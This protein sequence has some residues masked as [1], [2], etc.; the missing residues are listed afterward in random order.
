MGKQK[1]IRDVAQLAGVS[2]ATASRVLSDADY[3]IRPQLRQRVREAAEK[4]EYVR[5]RFAVLRR[6]A[7]RSTA[8]ITPTSLH[9]YAYSSTNDRQPQSLVYTFYPTRPRL[10]TYR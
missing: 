3:P 7:E 5:S 10:R 6:K 1:T 4:L 8:S 2:V 9:E